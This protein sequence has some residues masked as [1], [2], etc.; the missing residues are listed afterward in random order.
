MA[1]HVEVNFP[2]FPFVAGFGQEGRDQPQEGGFIGEDAG[3]ILP[4]LKPGHMRLGVLLEVELAALPR[5]GPKDGF[6]RGRHAGMVVAD[7]EL[8]AAEAALDQA[9]EEASPMPSAS[10]RA[11][12]TP[13]RE[14]WP[15][16][17]MPRAR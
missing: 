4:L 7:D 6:A 11:T 16:G 8:A 5:D 17:E 15:P 2:Q 9:L 12:L 14:R 10:L 3:D 1:F 13:N